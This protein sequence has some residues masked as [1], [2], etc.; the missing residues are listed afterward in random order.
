MVVA[1]HLNVSGMARGGGT[2]K[3]GLNRAVGDAA[4][5]RIRGLLDYKTGWN[6]GTLVPA[7]RW[8]PSSQLC[9]RCGAKT[10][11]PLRERVYRC[12]AGCPEMDRDLNAAI[13]LARLGEPP[14][15]G[16]E[17]GTGTGSGP[18]TNHRVGQGRGANHKTRPTDPVGKAGGVEASTPHGHTADRT[19]TVDPQGSA[20]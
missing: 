14:R 13:N 11:L 9:S 6:G 7:G 5:G 1:E 17:T 10:K 3:R 2:A 15:S 18:A 19:G 4:L 8:F 16:G 12:R 20:A